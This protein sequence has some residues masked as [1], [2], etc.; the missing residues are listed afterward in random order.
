MHL[1]NCNPSIEEK[2]RVMRLQLD[3]YHILRHLTPIEIKALYS[4]LE[5]A[6]DALSRALDRADGK[7]Y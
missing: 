6:R 7:S 2:Q 5:T 4:E 1:I 3:A